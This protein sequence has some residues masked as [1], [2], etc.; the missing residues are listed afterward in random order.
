MEDALPSGAAPVA[1]IAERGGAG[2]ADCRAGRRRWCRR[3]PEVG[4]FHGDAGMHQGSGWRE[5]VGWDWGEV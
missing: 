5:C 1:P 4:R 3:R 2:G